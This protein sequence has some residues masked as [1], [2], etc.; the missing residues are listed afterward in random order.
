MVRCIY[1]LAHL[2][3]LGGNLRS[4][5]DSLGNMELDEYP[6]IL[7]ETFAESAKADYGDSLECCWRVVGEEQLVEYEFRY[8]ENEG[9][10]RW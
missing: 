8:F 6:I 10:R 3:D 2:F 9:L 4:G 5:H 7:C 1:R